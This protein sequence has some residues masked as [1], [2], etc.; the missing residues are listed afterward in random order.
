[1]NPYLEK[2]VPLMDFIAEFLGRNTELVLHDLSDLERSVVA[3][4]NG[5]I[6]Q[7]QIGAPITDLALQLLNEAKY[8]GLPFIANYQGKA[9]NGHIVKSGTFFIRDDKDEIVGML[10]LNADLQNFVK[11]RD[12]LEV[13][14]DTMKIP[15]ET[16]EITENLTANVNDLIENNILKV[17]PEVNGGPKHL[18]QKE[19]VDIVHQLNEMGTFMMKGSVGYVAD[20]LD[21]SIPTI[22]RYLNIVKKED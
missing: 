14:I 8:K 6:S 10:C 20:R 2:F 21:V 22:Y 11:A 9:F 13:M 12:L 5:H 16:S 18:T 4:R 19:K 1:M 7:R 3:I 15:E 17:Y